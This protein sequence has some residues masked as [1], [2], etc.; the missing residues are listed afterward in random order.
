MEERKRLPRFFITI[1]SLF[2]LSKVS[3]SKVILRYYCSVYKVCV[4]EVE[5][6]VH[7]FHAS[8]T[9][10]S[11]EDIDRMKRRS[12]A[13][14]FIPTFSFFFLF[15]IIIFVPLFFLFSIPSSSVMRLSPTKKKMKDGSGKLFPFLTSPNELDYCLPGILSFV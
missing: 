1:K 2:L 6:C 12:K 9:K 13:I 15:F 4:D 11:R 10:A 7:S 8:T 5:E 14:F 3:L